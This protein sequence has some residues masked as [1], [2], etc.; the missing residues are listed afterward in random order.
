LIAKTL[1]KTTTLYCSDLDATK[2][3]Y[4]ELNDKLNRTLKHWTKNVIL[5]HLPLHICVVSQITEN[6]SH[7]ASQ[8]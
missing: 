2:L 6:F 4:S 7:Q 1:K 3:F 8:N 5:K